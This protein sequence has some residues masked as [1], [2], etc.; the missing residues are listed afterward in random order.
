MFGQHFYHK[1]IRN[2]VIAFGTI[3][4][5]INIK[6]LDSSGNPL[7]TIRVP[8]SYAPKEK[9]IAKELKF[10]AQQKKHFF[11][12]DKTHRF[13]MHDFDHKLH[14]LRNK[15]YT[16]FSLDH[17]S[18]D[19]ITQQIGKLEALKQQE[20][21]AFFGEVRKLCDE[22]QLV[23]FETIIKRAVQKRGQRPPRRGVGL[24]RPPLHKKQ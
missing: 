14:E 3:F 8:L 6:R 11:S 24:E 17:F 10:S 2:T 9:F 15:L 5:N 4:N 23:K 7:Q 18:S 12:L 21:F 13:Q 1:T 20:L 19:S 22:E 16:S